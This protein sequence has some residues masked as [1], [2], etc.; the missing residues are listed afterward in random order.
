MI[1]RS[2]LW[3]RELFNKLRK[4]IYSRCLTGGDLHIVLDDGNVKDSDLDFCREEIRVNRYCNDDH[5]LLFESAVLDILYSLTE[6]Q[7][8]RF[9]NNGA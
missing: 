2:F 4:E 1:V 5:T 6:E 7:R 3:R 9:V 8:E